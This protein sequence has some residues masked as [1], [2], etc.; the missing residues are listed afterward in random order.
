MA[1]MSY[2]RFQNTEQD[3]SDCYNHL[4]DDGL[5]DDEKRARER[6]IRLCHQIST[7]FDDE[8]DSD[9]DDDE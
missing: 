3:L 5:S 6:L 2:C 8:N 7:E 4:F 1:N 9:D